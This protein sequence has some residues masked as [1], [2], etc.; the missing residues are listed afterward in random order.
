MKW[1]LTIVAV[2][3]ALLLGLLIW[4]APDP[5]GTCDENAPS[6]TYARR[7]SAQRLSELHSEIETLVQ[8]GVRLNREPAR[9]TRVPE[10]LSDLRFHN[11]TIAGSRTRL[12][13][14]GCMD[15]FV[16]ITF[17]GIADDNRPAVIL[18]WGEGPTRGSEEIWGGGA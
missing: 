17:R 13:L 2:S 5:G 11:I 18:Q 6:V 10:S 16:I 9:S 12:M 15:T 14:D 3:A 8:S 1:F 4:I 7:L